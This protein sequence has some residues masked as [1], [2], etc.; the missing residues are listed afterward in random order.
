MRLSLTLAKGSTTYLDSSFANAHSVC[1]D[2][3]LFK[4]SFAMTLHAMKAPLVPRTHDE[5]LF[6]CPF[7]QRPSSVVACAVNRAEQIVFEAQRDPH[8]AH[9]HLLHARLCEVG[10]GANIDP[11]LT[12]LFDRHAAF[13]H[14]AIC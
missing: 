7:A 12:E 11:Y 5:V 1:G 9:G 6:E 14:R 10:F 2:D 8:A 4:P 13:Y 3:V